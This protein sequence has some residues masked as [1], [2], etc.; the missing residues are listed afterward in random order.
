[1]DIAEIV[2]KAADKCGFNRDSYTE[3]DLPTLLSNIIVIPFFGDT[4]STCIA[5][6]LILRR[7]KE[8]RTG[9]YIIL[10]SW[11]GHKH[12]FP[13]VDEYWS[14]RDQS[15]VQSLASSAVGFYNHSNIVANYHRFLNNYFEN[16]VT[17]EE[18]SLY[19]GGFTNKYWQ[20]FRDVRLFLPEVPSS[21]SLPDD[22]RVEMG[23]SDGKKV[24]IFPSKRLESWQAGKLHQLT[25]HRDFWC[26][27][28]TR[29]ISAGY[30]PVVY[31]NWFTY[32]L[33]SDFADKCI[34]LTARDAGQV[35]SAMRWADCVLDIHSGVSRMATAARTPSLIADERLR[36][37]ETK[38]YE[39][40]DLTNLTPRQYLFSFS[41]MLMSGSTAEWNASLLD[42]I[43]SRL[44]RWLPTIDRTACG[45]PTEYYG[46]ADYDQVRRHKVRRLGIRFIKKH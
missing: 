15:S 6:S 12:L 26:A 34:W 21:T 2:R 45:S 42:G 27:A 14:I 8:L 33:S 29:L 32:D 22:F 17:W 44:D 39:L 1:M 46:V 24:V 4:R 3:H 7:Y 30:T 5:S 28:A 40:D 41:T 18:L 37:V 20:Q 10:C 43:V 23:K 35:L 25:I 11:P 9:K 38:T 19:D 16:I 13:Y 36:Y 31:Q